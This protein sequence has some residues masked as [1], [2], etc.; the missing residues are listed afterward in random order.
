MK[1]HIPTPWLRSPHDMVSIEWEVDGA[2]GST[3]CEA[4]RGQREI[5]KLERAGY[6]ITAVKPFK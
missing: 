2:S 4:W 1:T 6:R 3:Q 5:D